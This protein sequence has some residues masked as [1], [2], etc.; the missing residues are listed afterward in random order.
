MSKFKFTVLIL[1]VFGFILL[2]GYAASAQL[3]PGMIDMRPSMNATMT[4]SINSARMRAMGGRSGGSTAGDRQRAAG[5]AKI[6]AGK[7]NTSFTPSA[8]ATRE[9]VQTMTWSGPKAPKTLDG[10]VAYVSDLTVK[11]NKIVSENKLT[12]NDAVDGMM[13]AYAIAATI[14]QGK[15]PSPQFLNQK[16]QKYRN[17]LLN[18]SYYQGSSSPVRQKYYENFAMCAVQALTHTEAANNPAKSVSERSKAKENALIN[19]RWILGEIKAI[20]AVID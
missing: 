17:Y 11:F 9:F 6:R 3:M 12:V 20:D 7:A 18:D 19:T 13:L 8:T 1:Q 5:A 2:S 10:Q 14:E 15:R 16:R 4:N